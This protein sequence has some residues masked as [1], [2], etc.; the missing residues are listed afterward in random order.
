MEFEWDEV[1]RQSNLRKHQIDFLRMQL[2][3]DG[4]PQISAKSVSS[5]EPRF[6]T[7]GEIDG[8]FY[9]VVWTWRGGAVRIISA[10][11]ARDAERRDY[12]SL[13]S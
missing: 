3:F 4:R 9:T 8:V 5:N 10:R 1:K 2:L 7:T 11:R 13:H 6:L 12:R